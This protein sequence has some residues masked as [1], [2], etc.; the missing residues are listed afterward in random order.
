MKHGCKMICSTFH[1][2][3]FK[4]TY[5]EI[6]FVEPGTTVDSLFAMYNFGWYYNDDGTVNL[7]KNPT[8]MKLGPLQKTASDI[9]GLDF[10]EILPK[11]IQ[12]VVK[13]KKQVAIA[14][15]GTSQSKYWNR[16]KGWQDVIDWCNANGYEAVIVSKE[17]PGYMKNPH[18]TGARKLPVGPI[19]KVMKEIKASKAFVGIG[20]G[21]SW[22]AWAMEVPIVLVSGFSYD[23][24][25]MQ[26]NTRRVGAP[27]GKCSGCFNRY[28][29]NAGD[30]NWCPDH[31]GTQRAYECSR[32]ITS[33]SVIAELKSILGVV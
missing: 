16:A 17:D 20:S 15:H 30:W 2:S 24:T 11:L 13:K 1:N 33:E 31:K 21:L 5:P 7:N 25:E 32:S 10:V 3:W 22:I 26:T 12:P 8:D 18:P 19:D 6:E 23:Y 4:K 27:E 28:K 29:L 9:L 14:I